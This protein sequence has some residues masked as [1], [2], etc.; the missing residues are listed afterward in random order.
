M[1]HS[2][3]VPQKRN[4]SDLVTRVR[5]VQGSP[6]KSV[7]IRE[8]M[9]KP[10]APAGRERHLGTC[11]ADL[12]WHCAHLNPSGKSGWLACGEANKPAL[13]WIPVSGTDRWK[14]SSKPAVVRSLFQKELYNNDFSLFLMTLGLVIFDCCVSNST[15]NLTAFQFLMP[16]WHFE[17][18]VNKKKS[19]YGLLAF[20]C[21][22]RNWRLCWKTWWLCLNW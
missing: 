9:V 21:C 7:P 4:R 3:R 17:I 8:A 10:A 20:L 14:Q 12:S 13:L 1:R 15:K 18:V 22:S 11:T 16:L 6:D 2:P 19:S 5:P